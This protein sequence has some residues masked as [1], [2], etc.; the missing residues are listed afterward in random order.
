M[1][2]MHWHQVDHMQTIYGQTTTPT[3]HRLIFTGQPDARPSV[4]ALKAC[5]TVKEILND[6]QLLQCR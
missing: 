6:L 5:S 1:N 2:G 4:K 3:R